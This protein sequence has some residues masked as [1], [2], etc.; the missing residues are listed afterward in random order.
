MERK[1]AR[2]LFN[3]LAVLRASWLVLLLLFGCSF[4][5]RAAQEATIERGQDLLRHGNYKDAAA[6]FNTLLAKNSSDLVAAEGLITTQVETGD[7]AVAEK[8]ASELADRGASFNVLLGRIYFETG[9]YSEAAT[10]FE[11]A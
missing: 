6:V 5:S 1:P 4:N 9:R 8:R 3:Y 10:Q 7:Y 11:R 2:S